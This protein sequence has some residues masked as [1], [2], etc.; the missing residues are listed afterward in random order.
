[1]LDYP[2]K[3]GYNFAASGCGAARLARAVRVGEVVGS[4]PTIP[5]QKKPSSTKEGFFFFQ[6]GSKTNALSPGN[7]SGW[8]PGLKAA[9]TWVQDGDSGELSVW[10]QAGNSWNP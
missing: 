10:K 5:T 8:S 9:D 1:M 6:F 7:Q 4:N 3:L 2:T